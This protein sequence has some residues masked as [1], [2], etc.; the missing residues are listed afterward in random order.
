MD[1]FVKDY[2]NKLAEI[3]MEFTPEQADHILRC[4]DDL[5]TLIRKTVE[6]DPNYYEKW[7]DMTPKKRLQIIQELK[8]HGIE[9]TP[10][11]FDAVT[12]IILKIYRLECF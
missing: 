10:D 2:R 4:I 5:K 3:G 6:K 9:T 8:E 1:D 12:E 11:E 7:A